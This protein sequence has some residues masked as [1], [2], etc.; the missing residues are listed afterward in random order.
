MTNTFV[1]AVVM[2]QRDKLVWKEDKYRA[3]GG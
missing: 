3:N 1:K 2:I